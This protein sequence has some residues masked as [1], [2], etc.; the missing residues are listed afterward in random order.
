MGDY[1]SFKTTLIIEKPGSIIRGIYLRD[2][3]NNPGILEKIVGILGR[4][5]LKIPAYLV[6]DA[7]SS[8]SGLFIY[9]ELPGEE[10]DIDKITEELKREVSTERIEWIDYPVKGFAHSPFFPLI[11]FE[12]RGVFF[13]AHVLGSMFKGYRERLGVSVAKTIMYYAGLS[14]GKTRASD[15]MKERPDL[16]KREL[17]LRF[18]LS[19][20]ALGQYRSELILFDEEKPYI[21]IRVRDSWECTYIGSGYNEPQCNFIR[22]FFE[23]FLEGLLSKELES[24]EVKCQCKGDPYCEFHIKPA[25]L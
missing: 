17:L 6:S 9:V 8:K 2:V 11:A 14:G 15:V 16:S 12:K 4:Y 10:V 25:I 24:T 5:G 22:G 7:E 20:F 21:I 1:D 23:G 19:G 3:D 13:S 18:L